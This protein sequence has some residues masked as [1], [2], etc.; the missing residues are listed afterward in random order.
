MIGSAAVIAALFAGPIASMGDSDF[1]K[2]FVTGFWQI[3]FPMRTSSSRSGQRG[4]PVSGQGT[5]AHAGLCD[6]P[7]RRCS[8]RS[9]HYRFAFRIN[10]GVGLGEAFKVQWPACTCP[11]QASPSSQRSPRTTWVPISLA[12]SL[13]SKKFTQYSLSVFRST[14][15]ALVARRCLDE[16]SIDREM[17]VAQEVSCTGLIENRVEES[18]RNLTAQNRSRLLVKT[19]TSQTTFHVQPDEPAERKV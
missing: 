2:S 4:L 6:P 16:H 15:E 8:R 17:I 10:H 1:L 9:E 18:P 13:S 14:F 3:A 19:V 12:S 11:T 7:G 5:S